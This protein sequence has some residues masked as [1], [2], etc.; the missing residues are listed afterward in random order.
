MFF[1][2]LGTFPI[3]ALLSFGMY[4]IGNKQFS[5]IIFKTA[6]LVVIAFAV[7]NILNGLVA[8]GIIEPFLNL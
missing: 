6:G 7:F 2:A 1:F 8:R 3:L 5:G 4:N